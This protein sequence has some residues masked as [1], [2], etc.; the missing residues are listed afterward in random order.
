MKFLRRAAVAIVVLLVAAVG[1][2]AVSPPELI[3]VG[4]NYTAKIVCSNVFLAGRDEAEVLAVDVQA[5]GH[6]LLK[7]MRVSVDREAGTVRTGLFGFIGNGLAVHRGSSAGC[8]SVPGG[9]VAAVTGPVP[10]EGMAVTRIEA[11]W[12]VGDRVETVPDTEL[13]AVLADEALAG[14]GMRAIVVVRDGRIIAERYGEGFGPDTRLLGWSM[15]KTATAALIGRAVREGLLSVDDPAGVTAWAGDRRSAIRISDLA[16]MASDLAWN[17]GYGSVSDVTRMLYLEDDMAGF[18]EGQPLDEATP[19]GIGEEFNYSSGTTVLLSRLWQDSFADPQDAANF[20]KNAL[21]QPLRMTS[22]VLEMDASGTYVGSS[23]LYATAR[24][25]ARFGQFL[26]Q[27]GVWNG[28]SL[29]PVGFV[30]WMTEPH[31]ASDGQ[32]GRG[33]VW[34]RPANAWMGEPIP[35]LPEDAFFM[36]GHDGQSVSVIPSE[37]LVVVRMGLTPSEQRYQ[38]AR[39]ID[40]VMKAT[41]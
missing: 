7:L 18:V 40:A 28:R 21:F 14:P 3:R 24:D 2:L 16:G 36:N 6:P 37:G 23:Y 32:Y 30:D 22:A 11:P 12:P 17:E 39:L 9:D 10:P 34:L 4:A 25:W 35:E 5:P 26:L 13:E 29:L 8:S 41:R 33:Q 31:P 38:V 1:W 19:G 15:T 20:P 27:R